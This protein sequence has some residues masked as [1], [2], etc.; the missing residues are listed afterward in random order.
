MGEVRP[1]IWTILNDTPK[2]KKVG[3]QRYRFKPTLLLSCSP[4]RT[5]IE[6]FFRRFG[7]FGEAG[8]LD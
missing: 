4:Y 8:G 3:V 2:R 6:L 1:L 5:D 7:T